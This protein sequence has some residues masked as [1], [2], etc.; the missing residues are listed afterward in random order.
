MNRMMVCVTLALT[1]A[2]TTSC[3]AQKIVAGVPLHMTTL[4]RV[5][6]PEGQ[7]GPDQNVY[8]KGYDLILAE[9]WDAA[10]KQFTELLNK[11]PKSNYADD[12]SY[13]TAYALMHT[14][15]K[16]AMTTYKEFVSNYPKSTYYD[17]AVADMSNIEAQLE[18]ARAQKSSA[19]S[20]MSRAPRTTSGF[21]TPHPS[22]A[23]QIYTIDSKMRHFDRTMRIMNRRMS[24]ISV[25]GVP[26]GDATNDEKPLDAKTRL[27]LDALSALGENTEDV[28]AFQ[29][30]KEIALD[31]KQP[32]ILRKQALSQ[33]SGFKNQDID[34]LYLD[35]AKRDTSQDIQVLAIENIGEGSDDKVKTVQ[36]LGQLYNSLP[37]K[38]EDQ[39]AAALYRIA[40]VGNDQAIDFLS[41]IA[42]TDSDYDMRSDAVYYLGNIGGEKARGVLYDILKGE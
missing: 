16:K 39:R 33:L 4:A 8:K 23:P 18:L 32:L 7:E 34:A 1:L 14:D 21:A 11:Y 20:A 15:L 37:A 24:G 19:A 35:L 30:L 22:I 5:E 10:R 29:T 28:K 25:M 36:T 6:E 13:W 38:H 40:D 9:K 26:L 12:A 31:T 3:F 41:K 27:K 17:D 2:A 42:R